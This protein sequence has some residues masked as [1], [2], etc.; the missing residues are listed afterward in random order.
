[1]WQWLADH[2]EFVDYVSVLCRLRNY[3]IPHVQSFSAT[4]IL[5]ISVLIIHSLQCFDTIGWVIDKASDLSNSLC[6][7]SQLS[8]KVLFW[9]CVKKK[10]YQGTMCV[11]VF[12]SLFS[13]SHC[14]TDLSVISTDASTL[15][16]FE[17]LHFGF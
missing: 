10:G 3:Y 1:M 11:S 9:N 17:K 13:S 5:I 12:V 2:S 6:P 15:M 16:S 14:E 4:A 8:Q 7:V